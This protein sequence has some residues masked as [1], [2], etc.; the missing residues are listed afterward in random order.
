VTV[1]AQKRS[2]PPQVDAAGSARPTFE[3]TEGEVRFE[4]FVQPNFNQLELSS[5]TSV[6][7]AANEIQNRLTLRWT[8]CSDTPGLLS[9]G[10]FLVRAEPAIKSDFLKD[11]LI[12]V[13]GK[14]CAAPGWIRRVRAMQTLKKPVILFSDA[15]TEY[16]KS[17]GQVDHPI[18][19]HWRDIPILNE[20]G[21]F[22]DLST[23]LAEF[24]RGVLTCSGQGY[25][26]EAT[27][28]LV[29]ELLNPQERSD[30]ASILVM[31]TA[32][33]FHREQP[34]GAAQG[35]TFLEG[36]L[37]KAL[38]LMEETIEEPLSI[39]ELTKRVGVSTRQLERL[40]KIQLNSS[41]AKT[42]RQIRLNRARSLIVETRLSLL[43]I[44]LACGF[45][46]TSAMAAPFRQAFG[47][48]PSQ[49]RSEKGQG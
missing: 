8:M 29:S 31:D 14:G 45:S 43:D 1:T 6:L 21:D 33:G 26:L 36:H 38:N 16:T 4:I 2:D 40:F 23:S 32:R 24:G 42:Y 22:S 47:V 19:V 15:A 12:V 27:F 20:I 44:A 9:N 48:S 13:G 10:N 11:C 30:L 39:V 25:A 35:N 34:K 5:V 49:L 41:P 18:A 46:N 17:L 3:I 37:Q 28:N 7:E